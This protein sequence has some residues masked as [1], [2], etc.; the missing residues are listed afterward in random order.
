[1]K[2]GIVRYKTPFTYRKIKSISLVSEVVRSSMF[3]L[4]GCRAIEFFKVLPRTTVLRFPIN[5]K[6]KLFLLEIII[7][8]S[9]EPKRI[10]SHLRNYTKS[11]DRKRST[12][13]SRFLSVRSHGVSQLINKKGNDIRSLCFRGHFS[14]AASTS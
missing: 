9:N 6:E 1:M 12:F 13:L 10:V 2:H 8:R 4:S 3:Y 7:E 11:L 5:A 14:R